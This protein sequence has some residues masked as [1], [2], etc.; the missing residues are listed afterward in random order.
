M[1]SH[2]A[3][4]ADVKARLN[5]AVHELRAQ[6]SLA[7]D[8]DCARSRAAFTMLL[9]NGLRI[10]CWLADQHNSLLERIGEDY[11]LPRD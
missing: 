8:I 11:P 6:Q 9:A 10:Y 3:Q 7:P 2:F 1:Q 4:L 5:D